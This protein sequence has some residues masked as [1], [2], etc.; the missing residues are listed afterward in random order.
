MVTYSNEECTNIILALDACGDNASAA[1]DYYEDRYP[2]RWHSIH[3]IYTLAMSFFSKIKPRI[4][5]FYSMFSIQFPMWNHHL[6]HLYHQLSD[7]L[8]ISVIKSVL[9]YEIPLTSPAMC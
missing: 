7:I 9:S 5:E 4:K 1:A 3:R 8:Y 2:N 6:A